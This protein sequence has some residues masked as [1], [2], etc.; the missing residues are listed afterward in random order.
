MIV[1]CLKKVRYKI[2]LN[3]LLDVNV[4][5][6][7]KPQ[8]SQFCCNA[9]ISKF[10]FCTLERLITSWVSIWLAPDGYP[11]CCCNLCKKLSSWTEHRRSEPNSTS[12]QSY[13]PWGV[14]KFLFGPGARWGIIC[15][16]FEKFEIPPLNS[17]LSFVSVQV[18]L[19]K[20]TL[21]SFLNTKIEIKMKKAEPGSWPRLN[22]VREVKQSLFCWVDVKP[23]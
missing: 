18:I 23:N 12:R 6:L 17:V 4:S 19:D 3:R 22:I 1:K 21:V 13:F 16:S 15:F 14:W 11:C 5:S 10:T 20:E 8:M 2:I 7:M 9:K